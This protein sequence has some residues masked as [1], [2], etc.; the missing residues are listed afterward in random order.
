[1][2]S[3]TQELDSPA[4]SMTWMWK[5][6]R[7]T[8]SLLEVPSDSPVEENSNPLPNLSLEIID[9][10][11][12]LTDYDTVVRCAPL[13]RHFSSVTR[14]RVMENVTIHYRQRYGEPT[15]SEHLLAVLLSYPES[16]NYI[17]HIKIEDIGSSLAAQLYNAKWD[18]P[19]LDLDEE[20]PDIKSI[21]DRHTL[22]PGHLFHDLALHRI[23]G[24]PWLKGLDATLVTTDHDLPQSPWNYEFP[25]RSARENE[26]PGYSDHFFFWIL[27]PRT[28]PG[29]AYPPQENG[30]AIYLHA[31]K[32]TRVLD[33]Q[34]NFAGYLTSAG[35][36]LNFSKLRALELE[37]KHSADIIVAGILLNICAQSLEDLKFSTRYFSSNAGDSAADISFAPMQLSKLKSLRSLYLRLNFRPVMGIREMDWF[38]ANMALFPSQNNLQNL[39]VVID[40]AYNDDESSSSDGCE[41][42]DLRA[43]GKWSRWEDV[44]LLQKFD[45]LKTLKVVVS[46]AVQ[47]CYGGCLDL[48]R[49]IRLP[50]LKDKKGLRLDCG[51]KWDM[52]VKTRQPDSSFTF[53][54][55]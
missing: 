52:T 18:D 21:T 54:N 55:C 7:L 26:K 16:A 17:R 14:K 4:S 44:F 48:F 31:L 34:S 30:D 50:R 25:S 12:S 32:M 45:G 22:S 8:N 20:N 29:R 39:E 28:R 35:S 13:S 11:F 41:R 37:I 9:N 15:K 43:Y 49:C 33:D 36:V 3:Q 42:L 38:L 53:G 5:K 40:L 1:M 27:R 47:D 10:I 24:L 51:E 46:S 23:P 19:Y 6:P 2:S